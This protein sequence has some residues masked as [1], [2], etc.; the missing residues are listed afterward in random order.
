MDGYI[1]ITPPF[2][3]SIPLLC[4]QYDVIV[5]LKLKGNLYIFSCLMT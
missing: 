2:S 3:F 5:D 1:S 4:Y